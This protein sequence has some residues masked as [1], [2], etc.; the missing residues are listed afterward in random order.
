M[1]FEP[2]IRIA[3]SILSAD[4]ADFGAEIRAIE[5]QGCDWV[6]VDV[7]DG[8]FVP[9][10]TFGPQL[11][12]AIRPHI[13][14]VMDVHLMIAPVDPYI[15]AFAEA[16]ADIITAHL[17]A[18]PHP[19]RTLQA[20]RATGKKAGLAL[21]PGTPVEAVD[22][23]LDLCDLILVMTVNPGFGGQKFIQTQVD[24]IRR[25]KALI[26]DRSILIEVDGGI[27]PATAPLV[28]DA[29]ARVLVAGSAVFRG[30]SVQVPSV[31]GDNIRT[32]REAATEAGRKA[33]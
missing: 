8:H 27:D 2:S 11:C 26:G 17:E 4:F 24:Q 16:G 18:G 33:A 3:P 23:L 28:A 29:G 25:L 6:H 20:I 10:L 32:L 9:N 30:G 7:M 5:Q 22:P 15:E 31:Y 14:T 1:T 19:H 21:N 13:T 12:K